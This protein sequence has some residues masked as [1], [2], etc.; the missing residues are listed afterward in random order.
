[1]TKYFTESIHPNSRKTNLYSPLPGSFFKEQSF[2][3]IEDK[4]VWDKHSPLDRVRFDPSLSF[5]ERCIEMYK[6]IMGTHY[7]E[8]L[9]LSQ[10][11]KQSTQNDASIFSDF[12]QEDWIFYFIPDRSSV[13][14]A[15]MLLHLGEY[16]SIKNENETGDALED[17]TIHIRNNTD[18]TISYT[19]K[20]LNE[21]F[22]DT[23][24]SLLSRETIPQL[25]KTMQANGHIT[26]KKKVVQL[27]N[28]NREKKTINCKFLSA[29]GDVVSQTI[30]LNQLENMI[31]DASDVGPKH[32]YFYKIV[33]EA[34]LFLQKKIQEQEQSGLGALSN[35]LGNVLRGQPKMY[36]LPN[37]MLKKSILGYLVK[38]ANS[39]QKIE[40]Y[41]LD[42]EKAKGQ[43]GLLDYLIFPLIARN[44]SYNV[45]YY[46]NKKIENAFDC[47]I[48]FILSLPLVGYIFA[49]TT[50]LLE[51]LRIVSAM[52]LT[53]ICAA[54]IVPILHYQ[55]KHPKKGNEEAF[56]PLGQEADD[57]SFYVEPDAELAAA[58]MGVMQKRF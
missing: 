20:G 45:S 23:G 33:L 4:L 31:N 38:N 6:A 46:H 11:A 51:A 1:M 26:N 54:T 36:P 9:Y 21:T 44:I 56:S 49:V 24:I 15:E 12:C 19:L 43:K 18:G 34:E 5:G 25:I 35:S 2:H 28:Y 39:T 16:L 47:S 37:E 40:Q 42:N 53:L 52:L 58:S 3:A 29:T 30:D 50:M 55:L 48:K 8:K 41:V 22:F 57:S 14:N 17:N 13:G 7:I 32:K 10:K 27:H